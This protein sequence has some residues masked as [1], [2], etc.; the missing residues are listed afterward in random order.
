MSS[1]AHVVAAQIAARTVTRPS[2][3]TSLSK[4]IIVGMST[5]IDLLI[6]VGIGIAIYFIY[7][8][9]SLL[10]Q[11][12][13]MVVIGIYTA[14]LLQGFH[15]AGL[16]R[17]S[18]IIHPLRQIGK[19]TWISSIVFLLMIGIAFALKISADFSRVWAFAWLILSIIP[20]AGSRIALAALV[21]R[22]SRN[23]LLTRNVVIYGAGDQGASLVEYI[24]RLDEPWNRIIGVFDDR[25][26]R[27]AGK[28]LA[29][30]HVL[31]NT[32][33][34]FDY[35]RE[36][37]IDE[38]LIAVPWNSEKRIIEIVRLFA[39]LPVNI[40]LSPDIV[41]TEFQQHSIGLNFGIPMLNILDKPVTGWEAVI[42]NAFDYILGAVILVLSLPLMALI[43][44][45]IKLESKGPLF[46]HQKRYGFNH[47]LIEVCK[48]RTMYIDLQDNNAEQLTTR[49]DP[50]VTRVGA[51]LRRLSLDEL[52]QLCNVLR[53]E[54]SVVGPR[55]HAISAKAGGRLY[56]D[57]VDDYAARH[58][59]KPGITGWAQ[60]NGWRGNT[61]HEKDILNRVAH[62]IYYIENWSVLFDLYIVF[63][64]IGSV[65]F[66]KNSY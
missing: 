25:V 14:A 26:K 13:Y 4:T 29:G 7:K 12:R 34:L 55:P 61:E 27:R 22:W 45:A 37:R 41:G 42:K 32:G 47:K 30:F 28:E 59:V 24:S 60:V 9:D 62:D 38:I 23:G 39:P 57:V 3:G 50:R 53:G 56:G 35:V 48:F 2:R 31:G 6:V 52:P 63:R 16:Y 36:H 43:A 33:D 21:K 66:G 8:P 49:N 11:T 46:F 20:L 65:L 15:H 58:R 5:L 64:T 18:S 1:P 51:V 19:I 44:I 17:F 10:S 54:M 40:R